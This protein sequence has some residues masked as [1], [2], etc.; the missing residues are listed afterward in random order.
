MPL[1]ERLK[2]LLQQLQRLV[3]S[4][5][6]KIHGAVDTVGNVADKT[7][8]GKYSD[9]IAKAGEKAKEGVGKIGG[10]GQAATDAEGVAS[11]AEGAADSSMG[12]AEG[13]A[14]AAASDAEG[15][16]DST[17]GAA[18]GE[19]GAAAGDG[20]G[21]ADAAMGDAEGA[22]EQEEQHH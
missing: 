8:R 16:A 7:T 17:M 5:R 4:N 21:A 13:D 10:D 15:A 20:E 12:A 19:A 11:D 14:G 18:E 2:E 22:G 9:Q 6:D 1:G 3:S